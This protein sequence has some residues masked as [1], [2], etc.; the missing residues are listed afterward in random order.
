M[1]VSTASMR[2]TDLL[3]ED[4]LGHFIAMKIKAAP[5]LHANLFKMFILLLPGWF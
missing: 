2:G 5:Y 3:T 1:T 4:A